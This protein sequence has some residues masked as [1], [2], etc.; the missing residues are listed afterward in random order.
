MRKLVSIAIAISVLAV[1]PA[2]S[3]DKATQADGKEKSQQNMADEAAVK[4]DLGA[5]KDS[6]DP[7]K[8]AESERK[9]EDAAADAKRKSDEKDATGAARPTPR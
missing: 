7:A 6:G 2:M 9:L 8:Q 1:A 5:A 3:Q 4:G